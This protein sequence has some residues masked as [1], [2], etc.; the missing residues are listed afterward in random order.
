MWIL[1]ILSDK[2][3]DIRFSIQY[4]SY[5]SYSGGSTNGWTCISGGQIDLGSRR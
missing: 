5:Q 3:K 2:Y 4:N 1:L